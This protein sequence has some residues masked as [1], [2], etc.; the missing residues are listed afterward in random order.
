M[1]ITAGVSALPPIL[2]GEALQ[3]GSRLHRLHVRQRSHGEHDF[4][5]FELA[6]REFLGR[7]T[8]MKLR[9]SRRQTELRRHARADDHVGGRILTLKLEAGPTALWGLFFLDRSCSGRGHAL[10]RIDLYPVEGLCPPTTIAIHVDRSRVA[11]A[12]TTLLLGSGEPS[13]FSVASRLTAAAASSRAVLRPS[14]S[15]LPVRRRPR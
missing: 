1:L 12:A 4:G 10:R 7:S 3:R 14:G 6:G 8:C 5:S 15:R 9:L 2:A 11:R 13:I